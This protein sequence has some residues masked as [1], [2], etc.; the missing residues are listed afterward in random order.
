MDRNE[1]NTT[2][3]NPTPANDDQ[4]TPVHSDNLS[5]EDRDRLGLNQDMDDEQM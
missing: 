1:D 4:N 5:F 2:Q 3:A